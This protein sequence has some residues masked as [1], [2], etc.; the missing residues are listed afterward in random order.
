MKN[1]PGQVS[2]AFSC[3]N[4]H[5]KQVGII[6]RGLYLSSPFDSPCLYLC[7]LKDQSTA[8][9]WL[10]LRSST[11]DILRTKW[12]QLC[13][14]LGGMQVTK[15]CQ[16]CLSTCF[17]T[18]WD[19]TI[20]V[21]RWCV[22]FKTPYLFRLMNYQHNTGPQRCRTCVADQK[23]ILFFLSLF[24]INAYKTINSCKIV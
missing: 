21:I 2:T 6:L 7:L 3:L 14:I 15:S 5:T 22:I 10:R 24:V 9:K 19:F 4:Q 11:S 12:W 13:L 1:A 17:Y 20:K 16:N 18:G 8:C 23:S